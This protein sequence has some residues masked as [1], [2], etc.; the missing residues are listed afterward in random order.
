M[1]RGHHRQVRVL[2]GVSD[3][4]LIAAAFELAYATRLR[5]PGFEHVFFLPSPVQGLLLGWSMLV[6]VGLGYWWGLYDRIDLAHPRVILRD[7]FRQCLLGAAS[8]ILFEYLRRMDLSRSF[9]AL[10]AVY[11]WVVLCLFRLNAGRILSIVRREFGM[12]RY[13]MV[14]GLS[15]VALRLGRELEEAAI[16]GVRLTGFIADSPGEVP[17]RIDLDSSYPVRPLAALP[18]LLRRHVIDE[19]IFAVDSSRLRAA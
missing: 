10:F 15:E 7:A 18:E 14:V 11:A 3:I 4:L 13:V 6:W 16:Y 19:I 1:F 9:V 5:L 17:E 2:F 8:L 12:A